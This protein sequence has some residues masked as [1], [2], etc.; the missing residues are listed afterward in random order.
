[1]RKIISTFVQRLDCKSTSILFD[2]LV[3]DD[4]IESTVSSIGESGTSAAEESSLIILTP[5][6]LQVLF[7]KLITAFSFT[8]FEYLKNDPIMKNHFLKYIR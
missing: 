1:M 6:S 2:F 4:G 8:S 7:L 3:D 5:L